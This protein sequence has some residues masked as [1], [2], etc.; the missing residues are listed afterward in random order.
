ML[1]NVS[2]LVCFIYKDKKKKGN[3]YE[4]MTVNLKK[5]GKNR[6]RKIFIRLRQVVHAI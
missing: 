4:I 5:K 2:Y 1:V 6:H 3:Y